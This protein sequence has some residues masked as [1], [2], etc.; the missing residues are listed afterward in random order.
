[1]SPSINDADDP[2]SRVTVGT[3]EDLGYNVDYS[4][5]DSYTGFNVNV[6]VLPRQQRRQL[7]KLMR[8][9]TNV[10]LQIRII[11]MPKPLP[12]ASRF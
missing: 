4:A 5:A 12:K 3:L 2:I 6:V 1:M 7:I 11:L 10:P 9:A 8:R